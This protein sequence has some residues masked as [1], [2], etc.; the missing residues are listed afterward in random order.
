M[1][2]RMVLSLIR[3]GMNCFKQG[4][5]ILTEAEKQAKELAKGQ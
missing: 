1:S 4:M 5:S 3:Q 2:L